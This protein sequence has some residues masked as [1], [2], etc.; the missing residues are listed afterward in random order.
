M[1][2]PLYRSKHGAIL[3]RELPEAH[4]LY[5]NATPER[6]GDLEAYLY[7]FGSLLD[8]FEATLE[9][10]YA[11]GFLE[12]VNVSGTALSI[13]PWLIPYAAE[14]LGADLL[15]PDDEGRRRELAAAA[16]LARRRGTRAAL[17]AAAEA[18]LREPVVLRDGGART[19]RSPS[20]GTPLSTHR[21]LTGLW[22]PADA[23]ILGQPLP[24][25]D[26]ATHVQGFADSRPG[27]HAVLPPGAPDS[28]RRMRAVQAGIGQPGADVRPE[29]PEQ[30]DGTLV[31][32]VVRDRRG[33]ACFPDSYEDRTPR[34]PDIRAPRPRRPRH[35]ELKRPD[36]LVLLV[37]PPAG[38]FPFAGVSHTG[39]L[40]FSEG[41]IEVTPAAPADA[42]PQALTL[43]DETSQILVQQSNAGPDGWHRV[44]G[45]R[46]DGELSIRRGTRVL[47]E[48]SAIRSLSFAANYEDGEL[49]ARRCIFERLSFTPA[50][51]PADASIQLEQVTVTG[52][53]RAPV[54]HASDC[55]FLDLA[56]AGDGSGT[57]AG[58]IRFSRTQ[59]GFD[60]S[61]TLTYAC[62]EGGVRFLTLPC[63]PSDPDLPGSPPGPRTAVFGEPG[64]GVLADTNGREVAR[65]AENG[66]ELGAY[67]GRA[68]LARLAAAT[69]KA[70][71]QAPLGKRVFA[72]YDN[73]LLAP[74]PA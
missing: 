22:H 25:P 56:L 69:A 63:L 65:G 30:G 32:F 74:L 20:L 24:P 61:T 43:V 1:P 37:R 67:N 8:R 13:Q 57:G 33:V 72:N 70:Q 17:D 7:G 51:A 49:I 39:V 64:Y 16:W 36:A 28:R 73:R 50:V 10:F 12:E 59:Q 53:A 27:R 11:D 54:L 68:H 44:R 60:P 66:G 23:A 3:Y 21:E 31:S 14:L 52:A 9:Q 18:I 48:D 26:P 46:I 45:M 42:D 4:R 58:C 47:I 34:A 29:R 15:A 55:L 62:T 71:G 19:L 6:L 35:T 2:H 38:I 40:R 41:E 5:D